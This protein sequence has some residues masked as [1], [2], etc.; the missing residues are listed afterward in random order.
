MKEEGARNGAGNVP[1][2]Y[3]KY[4]KQVVAQTT[5]QSLI[6]MLFLLPTLHKPLKILWGMRPEVNRG[7]NR[8]R[9]EP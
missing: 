1:E 2:N 9:P 3:S 7:A 4:N 8:I 5:Q 6:F